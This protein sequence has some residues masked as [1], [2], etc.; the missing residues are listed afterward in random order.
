MD[1]FDQTLVIE[2]Y[3]MGFIGS[4]LVQTLLQTRFGNNSEWG[5]NRGWQSEI[6][7]WNVFAGVVLLALVINNFQS[8]LIITAL[9]IL[10]TG[11]FINHMN[12]YRKKFKLSNLQGAIANAIGLIVVISWILVGH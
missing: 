5:L 1:W 6:A 12:A 7:I 2:V 10:S 11:F 4:F 9:A 8:K 3:I